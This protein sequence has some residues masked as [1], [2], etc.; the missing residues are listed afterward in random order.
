MALNLTVIVPKRYSTRY[1]GT[2][3]QALADR[4]TATV[5]SDDGSTLVLRNDD[6][7]YGNPLRITTGDVV[8]LDANPSPTGI[9]V[10]SEPDYAAVYHELGPAGG[11]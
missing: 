6:Y 7:W 9:G 10:I 4:C 3:G 5:E 2:N 11:D 8:L 1:D